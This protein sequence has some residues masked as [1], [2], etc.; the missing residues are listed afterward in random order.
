MIEPSEMLQ[1]LDIRIASARMWLDDF[2]QGKRKRPDHE[3]L[4]KRKDI[5]HF[6]EIRIAYQRALD[7]RQSTEK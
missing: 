7:R 4:T 6:N 2:S 1:W 3:I 5:E